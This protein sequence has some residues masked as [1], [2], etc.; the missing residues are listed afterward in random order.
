MIDPIAEHA[1][2]LIEDLELENLEAASVLH[3]DTRSVEIDGLTLR[4]SEEPSG[5]AV[6][7][8]VRLNADFDPRTLRALRDRLAKLS[9]DI[10]SINEWWVRR[11]GPWY[12]YG[13]RYAT[14]N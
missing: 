6:I 8:E 1:A 13:V 12:W 2:E 5:G 4:L 10:V 11:E 7:G 3:G 9:L 14:T